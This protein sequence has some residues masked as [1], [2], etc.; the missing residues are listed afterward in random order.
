MPEHPVHLSRRTWLAGAA[1][2]GLA[3]CA[4]GGPP[5]SQVQAQVQAQAQAPASPQTTAPSPRPGGRTDQAAAGPVDDPFR[6]LA[7]D[8]GKIAA[9]L[10]EAVS[11]RD[12]ETRSRV[13]EQLKEALLIHDVAEGM[14]VYPAMRQAGLQAKVTELTAEH[15]DIKNYLYQLDQMPKDSRQWAVTLRSLQQTISD[16][17]RDEEERAFPQ[18]REAMDARQLR[19]LAAS[20]QKARAE[21]A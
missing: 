14:V 8:H 11:A 12:A 5:R 20:M 3:G 17:V 9:L 4:Q 6:V 15:G 10:D 19:G 18:L 13:L 1:A 2:I 21:V 7:D 16:H